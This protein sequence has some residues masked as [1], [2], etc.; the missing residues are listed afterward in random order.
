M[1]CTSVFINGLRWMSVLQL[2]GSLL[3]CYL[4][5]RWLPHLHAWVNYIRVAAAFSILWAASML[6]LMVFELGIDPDDEDAVQ[7]QRWALAEPT[8][9]RR[10]VSNLCQNGLCLS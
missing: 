7:A 2:T 5:L 9:A 6:T 4:Y 10:H 8:I 3:L 1:T